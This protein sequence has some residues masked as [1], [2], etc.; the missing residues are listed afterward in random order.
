ME[1]IQEKSKDK[2]VHT[3]DTE[4]FQQYILD[5][6]LSG[7]YKKICNNTSYPDSDE[8]QRGFMFGLTW[9]SLSTC[10]F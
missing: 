7:E 4:E 8:F 6:I 1:T 2:I 3:I 9:A 10:K 5:I